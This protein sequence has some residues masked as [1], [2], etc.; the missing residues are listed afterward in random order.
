M[1]PRVAIIICSHNGQQYIKEQIVSC[2]KQKGVMVRLFIFDWNSSDATRDIVLE[3]ANLDGRISIV[4]KETAPGPAISFL[5]AVQEV[6]TYDD[7]YE[8]LA[9]CDQ[10][11]VWRDDKLQQQINAMH[12]NNDRVLV[13]SDVELVDEAAR[14]IAGQDGHY[15]SGSY[16]SPPFYTKIS[17]PSIILCNPC[18]GMTMLIP[19]KL[20][21]EIV[22]IQLSQKIIMH[23]WM[24][25]ILA[26]LLNFDVYL[27]REPLVSYRQHSNNIIGAKR[28]RFAAALLN[29]CDHY[30]KLF[31]QIK[32]LQ[33]NMPKSRCLY[34]G[35][36]SIPRLLFYSTY[37]SRKGKFV[38]AAG[39]LF[40][41]CMNKLRRT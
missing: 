27:I 39:L 41:V 4:K 20:V 29:V 24:I 10:D 19:K 13:C 17:D 9:L 23:D 26:T 1:I 3:V 32:Y 28:K 35:A 11:D 6:S 12:L 8:Y 37:L 33:L 16:Y 34:P 36:F 30:D 21:S 7:E 40:Y 2:L 18:I 15:G 22:R 5:S 14:L 31:E 25:A 38:N